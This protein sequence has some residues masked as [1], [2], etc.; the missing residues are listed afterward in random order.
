MNSKDDSFDKSLRNIMDEG[1]EM[2]SSSVWAGVEESLDRIAAGRRIRAVWLRRV[3]MGA[4]VAASLALFFV[5]GG[6]LSRDDIGPVV[7]VSE[8]TK[9]VEEVIS[10]IEPELDIEDVIYAD[11]V[12]PTQ[13]Y[14][15]KVVQE[16]VQVKIV[17]EPDEPDEAEEVE[18]PEE[19][20]VE[21]TQPVPII[22]EADEDDF[23]EFVDEV[24]E[25]VSR[26]NTSLGV[27]GNLLTGAGKKSGVSEYS[28]FISSTFTAIPRTSEI[29]ETGESNY[30]LPISAGI[31]ARIHFNDKWSLGLGVNYTNLN[32][33]FKGEYLMVDEGKTIKNLKFDKIVNS[34]HYIGIPI[35]VYYNI[36]NARFM[37]F[38]TYLG[39]TIEKGISNTFKMRDANTTYTHKE[40]HS[41]VQYSVNLGL[42]MEFLLGK[43]VSIY[44]DPSIRYY[45]DNNQPR[46]IRTVQPFNLGVEAGLR[47]NLR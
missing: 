18:V 5:V 44:I 3:A 32:R 21:E 45:M 7:A 16:P 20:V 14:E 27:A 29:S 15:K 17:D 12:R 47:F 38:Y 4:A 2:P 36:V 42:G 46:S 19:K 33:S 25:N 23:P 41:G 37:N 24:K 39:G 10:V 26:V 28:R 13:V 11:N 43:T 30:S 8:D 31:S 34:Q 1:M 9:R 6:V 22:D 35:N 40:P